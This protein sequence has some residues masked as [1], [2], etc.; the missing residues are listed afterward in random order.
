M[1]FDLRT[2]GGLESTPELVTLLARVLLRRSPLTF[3][4][5]SRPTVTLR[6]GWVSGGDF[7]GLTSPRKERTTLPLLLFRLLGR[8]TG[9]DR[10]V[11][12]VSTEQEVEYWWWPGERHFTCVHKSSSR[13][14]AEWLARFPGETDQVLV[15]RCPGACLEKW[16]GEENSPNGSKPQVRSVRLVNS[17]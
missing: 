5:D 12:P 9:S 4:F 15:D 14:L 10:A 7:V 11:T 3:V 8:A 17:E 13:R 6:K 1:E 2:R 16:T